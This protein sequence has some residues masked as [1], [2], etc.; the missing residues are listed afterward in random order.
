MEIK[1]SKPFKASLLMGLATKLC[2]SKNTKD[3]EGPT[4]RF[5][6]AMG[7]KAKSLE[8]INFNMSLWSMLLAL[9]GRL[10]K[11]IMLITRII[12]FI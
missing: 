2:P 5:G 9:T 7:M 8:G 4:T 6:F 11:E 10:K 3:S 12:L 1:K